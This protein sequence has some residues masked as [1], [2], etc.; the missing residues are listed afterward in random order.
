MSKKILLVEDDETLLGVLKYNLEKEG[1]QVATSTDGANALEVFRK[2]TPDMVVLDIM[3]PGLDGFEVCRILRKESS[4]PVLMLTAKTQ[5]VDKVIGL[6]LG[7]DDYMTK[8]FSIRELSARIKAILRRSETPL[9]TSDKLVSGDLVVDLKEH[10]VKLSDKE[11]ELSPKEFDL[12]AF[13]M[14]HKKRVFSR[15]YLLDKVWSYDFE[16]DERTVDVHIRWLRQKIET[17]PSQPKRL[18]TVR[19]SGYKFEG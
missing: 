9:E 10:K 6:E 4:V 1:Y 5:E 8:P 3:L 11:I 18:L 17:D 16:G 12:L 7:A 14:R 19:G 15:S 2:F 13:M